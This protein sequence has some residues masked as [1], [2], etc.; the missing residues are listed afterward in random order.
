MHKV[1][2]SQIF[3]SGRNLNCNERHVRGVE[4]SVEAVVGAH[5][6][7]GAVGQEKLVQ[8]P[9]AQVLEDHALGIILEHDTE[10]A[11]DVW[12][13]HLRVDL[14]LA[15]KIL[16]TFCVGT[17]PQCLDGHKGGTASNDPAEVTLIDFSEGTFAELLVEPNAGDWELPGPRLWW[18]RLVLGDERVHLHLGVVVR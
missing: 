3:H 4:E 15:L 2:G 13:P 18:W 17:G 11:D 8:V 7:L 16:L 14:N 6:R 5:V 9:L 1:M 12:M 10:E